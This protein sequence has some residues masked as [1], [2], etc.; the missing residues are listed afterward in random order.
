MLWGWVK[1]RL[2]NCVY[3][4]VYNDTY[5]CRVFHNIVGVRRILLVI[6]GVSI[7]LHGLYRPL[8]IQETPCLTLCTGG[9]YSSV[10]VQN[11]TSRNQYPYHRTNFVWKEN[12]IPQ[13]WGTA[14]RLSDGF[15]SYLTSLCGYLQWVWWGAWAVHTES[16]STIHEQIKNTAL[17]IEVKFYPWGRGW[18]DWLQAFPDPALYLPFS[19]LL[20]WLKILLQESGC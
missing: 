9:M 14:P 18:S 16:G 11:W 3:T 12:I 17:T 19:I 7:Y 20:T 10:G 4:I 2:I 6:L 13:N 5:Q 1:H 8:L 15:P